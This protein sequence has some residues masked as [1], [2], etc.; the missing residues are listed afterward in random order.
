M[1][2]K[3]D[4]YAQT[5]DSGFM[6]KGSGRFYAD[7]I[8]ELEVRDGDAVLDVGCGTGSVLFFIGRQRKIRGFGLDA[9]ENMIRLAQEKNPGFDF[10]TGDCAALPYADESMDVV[11][12]CMAYH[13]FPDQEQF[14]KEVLRVLKPGG[15]LYISDPRFPWIARGILNACFREAGFHTT[16]KNAADFEK[17]GFRTVRITKDFYVQVLHFVKEK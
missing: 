16:K 3:F 9:S 11:M 4:R 2:V 8:R 15:S 17:T 1:T 6:G 14:R 13:H 12:A 5:Y 10:I 7:L